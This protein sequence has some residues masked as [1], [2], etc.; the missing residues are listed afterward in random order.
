V[1]MEMKACVA[2]IP[3]FLLYGIAAVILSFFASFMG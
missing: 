1:T 3:H 2:A